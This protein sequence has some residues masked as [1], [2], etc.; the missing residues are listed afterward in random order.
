MESR[1]IPLWCEDKP[2]CK[3]LSFTMKRPAPRAPRGNRQR[4]HSIYCLAA[5]SCAFACTSV[6]GIQRERSEIPDASVEAS[7][8]AAPPTWC[9]VH[10]ILASKCQR[11]HGS[12]PAHGAPFELV[13]YEDTQA[14]DHKGQATYTRIATAVEEESMPAQYIALTPPVEPLLAAERT[15]VLDW[16]A[17]G[18]LLTGGEACEGRP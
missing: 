12:P 8:D 15:T 11:C 17:N 3:R 18:G 16:C 13:S 4:P 5:L 2:V 10:A 1:L 7:T 9:S 6:T 14:V